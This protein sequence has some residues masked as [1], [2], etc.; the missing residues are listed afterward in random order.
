MLFPIKGLTAR[1]RNSDENMAEIIG[2][3]WQRLFG[4]GIFQAIENK[5]NDKSIGLYSDYE[6]DENGAYDITVCCEV[7][8]AEHLPEG[9]IK[10]IIPAGTYAKFII[11]G[12]MQ[13]AVADFW[14]KLWEMPLNRKYSCDFEEYQSGTDGENAEIHI[15]ISLK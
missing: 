4:E 12:H 5:Q 10:K 3:L 9:V 1:T 6:T 14:T 2:R 15:Y 7:A 11:H 13:K 8:R